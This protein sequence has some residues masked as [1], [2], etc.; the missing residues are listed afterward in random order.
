MLESFGSVEKFHETGERGGPRTGGW[1][2][3]NLTFVPSGQPN[4]GFFPTAIEVPAKSP[5]CFGDH[6]LANALKSASGG[7]D[8]GEIVSCLL[9]GGDG[10]G[11]RRRGGGRNGGGDEVVGDDREG[12]ETP[13]EEMFVGA[14]SVGLRDPHLSISTPTAAFFEP[15]PSAAASPSFSSWEFVGE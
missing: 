9:L 15:N 4:E 2:T 10:V 14:L 1:K 8:G 13:L 11:G 12:E 6:K 7:E 3:D 5:I